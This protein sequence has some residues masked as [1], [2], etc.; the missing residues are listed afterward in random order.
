[1]KRL[2]ACGVLL[3]GVLL[4]AAPAQAAAEDF[5]S[6]GHATAVLL[7]D[8]TTAFDATDRSVFLDALNAQV[9]LLGAGD[10]LVAY[11]MTGAYTESRKV[12][13][14]CKPGCPDEGFFGGLL[15][16]CR[17]VVAR[18]QY[19]GF[20]GALAASLAALLTKPE[21]TSASDLFRTV[22]EATRASATPTQPVRQL[23]L[24]SD[25]IENSPVLSERDAKRLPAAEI[26]K[27]LDAAGLRADIAG[28]AV[29]VFG[30]GRD[31]TPGRP[32]LPQDQRRRLEA[33]WR[34]WFQA[35]GAASVEIGFR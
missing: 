7:I 5:C 34:G 29:R 13:D 8:R 33:A 3:G 23:I 25:L 12:F 31:D 21:E 26:L 30:F 22:A 24:F 10:R 9:G 19:Q 32:P 1:M 17:P 14:R 16:T 11:T 4:G 15:S 20:V 18:A 35:G 6:F 2:L 28:A 27:R